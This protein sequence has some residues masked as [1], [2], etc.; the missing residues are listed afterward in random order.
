MMTALRHQIKYGQKYKDKELVVH[1]TGSGKTICAAL[2]LGDGRDKDALVVCPKRIKDKWDTTLYVWDTKATILTKEQFKKASLKKWSA[3]VI[4]EADEYASPLFTKNR[5]QL[6]TKLY[7]LVKMQ[8][9][10]PILLLTATPV[11]S[12][13]W[14]LHTL[15]C[16]L[17]VYIDYK[18]WRDRFFSLER[19]PFLPRPA[20]MPKTDWRTDIRPVLEKYSDIVLLKDCVGE[21]PPITERVVDVPSGVLQR[22]PEWEPSAAFV[23]EHRH[24]QLNKP[25]EI[26]EIGKNYRKVLVVAHF[27]EQVET[28]KK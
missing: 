7:E 13:P 2:W 3:I 19:R 15:L 22:N 23:A 18:K 28:L 11:R 6:S 8:P 16:F 10:T 1:E 9:E 21:L 26:M 25:A 5:S 12:N 20:W 24:E 14:N 4:D 17:G 27:V